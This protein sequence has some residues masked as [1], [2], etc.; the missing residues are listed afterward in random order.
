MVQLLKILLLKLAM[1]FTIGEARRVP[2]AAARPLSI[3]NTPTATCSIQ[4]THYGVTEPKQTLHSRFR[5]TIH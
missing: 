5:Y 2:H 3:I 4:S 1:L